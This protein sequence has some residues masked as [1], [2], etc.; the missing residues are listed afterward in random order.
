MRSARWVAI[1]QASRIGGQLLAL[2]ILSRLLPPSDYGL[3]AMAGVVT[4]LAGM[5]RDMGTG[6][7][8]IQRKELSRELLCTVFWLNMALGTTLG[9]GLCAGSGLLASL[10]REPRLAGVL[11]ALALVFPITSFTGVHQAI[12]E[13]R[14]GFKTLAILE[15]ANQVVGLLCAIA[16]ALS[17]AGVYSL[18]VPTV[19]SAVLSSAW[20]WAKSGWRPE[21]VWSAAEFKSLWG[22]TGSLTAFNFVNYFARNADAM[23]IGRLLGTTALGHYSMAYKLMLFPVQNLSW[24]VGRVLLPRL[25]QIQDDPDRIRDLYFKALRAVV[26]LSAPT[27]VALW[28]LR[29]PFVAI[30]FGPQWHDVPALIAWLA[31]VGF[32]Q[33][34]MSTTGTMFT[35]SG[36]TRTLFRIGLINSATFIFAFFV[37]AQW[38]LREVVIAYLIANILNTF[39][40]AWLTGRLIHASM[41]MLLA[42]IRAPVVS[43]AIMGG[44]MLAMHPLLMQVRVGPLIDV[45]SLSVAGAVIYISSLRLLFHQSVSHFTDLV[46]LKS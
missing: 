19:V 37:G 45:V 18:V 9:I 15:V 10:F 22:F 24:V 6:T 27:M 3:I 13:R 8:I 31:P 44:S 12:I 33:S 38:G 5:L 2:T 39:T 46:R 16:A 23:I 20:L 36:R 4:A 29:E 21:W 32:L 40:V 43:A 42:A 41:A 30:A 26:T 17:G 34:M 28:A 25:S 14:S 11:I 35:A 7:A 1:S